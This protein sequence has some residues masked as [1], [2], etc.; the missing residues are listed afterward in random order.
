MVDVEKYINKSFINPY[1]NSVAF[2]IRFPASV[3][4]IQDFSNFQD[5]INERYPNFG[6]EIP[7][8]DFSEKERAPENLKKYIFSDEGQKNK[9]RLSINSLAIIITDYEQFSTF[10]EQVDHIIKS[11]HDSY[12]IKNSLRMGL[13]YI[14]IYP[15]YSDINQSLSESKDLFISFLNTD[16]IPTDQVFSN[17]IEVRK[18]LPANIKISLRDIIYCWNH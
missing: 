1:L 11:F 15:L 12:G 5:L 9:V 10:K 3:R 13:R 14:N 17:N 6:E 2:E 18:N 16:L 8:F 7:F 4:V